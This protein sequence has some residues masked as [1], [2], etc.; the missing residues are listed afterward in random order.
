MKAKS[1]LKSDKTGQQQLQK[2]NDKSRDVFDLRMDTTGY[3]LWL[4]DCSDMSQDVQVR[5]INCILFTGVMQ[6]LRLS[7][8]FVVF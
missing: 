5:L 6:V 7:V 4:L 1:A 3:F 2:T 8:V